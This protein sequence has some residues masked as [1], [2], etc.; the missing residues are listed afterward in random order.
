M[1]FS[2]EVVALVVDAMQTENI[3]P[4]LAM[5]YLTRQVAAMVR[6]RREQ[7]RANNDTTMMDKRLKEYH[8][9][10]VARDRDNRVA[11]LP[12][13]GCILGLKGA[14][15]AMTTLVRWAFPEVM[16]GDG[17]SCARQMRG[18]RVALSLEDVAK[19]TW[20]AGDGSRAELWV[21]NFP[22][23]AARH[24]EEIKTAAGQNI[25][26]PEKKKVRGLVRR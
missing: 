24:Y 11:L 3:P 19:F 1:K 20:D 14:D 17:L 4:S 12:E 6:E 2:R 7:A 16:T 9:I 25:F 10:G 22:D 26:D 5:P 8:I 23:R 18:A 13:V 15:N 21:H